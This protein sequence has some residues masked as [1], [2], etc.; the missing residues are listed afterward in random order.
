MTPCCMSIPVN[1]IF[2]AKKI[3]LCMYKLV[4][5]TPQLDELQAS[6]SRGYKAQFG[7][8][9]SWTHQVAEVQS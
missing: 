4:D 5:I 3:R 8:S 7:R 9:Q 1:E 6:A 2:C